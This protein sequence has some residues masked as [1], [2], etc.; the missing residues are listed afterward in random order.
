MAKVVQRVYELADPP[1]ATTSIKISL[2]ISE[3]FG[4]ELKV[5][6]QLRTP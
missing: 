3:I 5:C 2:N 6:I 4:E 1:F